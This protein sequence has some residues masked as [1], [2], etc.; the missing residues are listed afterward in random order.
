MKVRVYKML[1]QLKKLQERLE[2]NP[3][4]AV[5]NEKYNTL[6]KSILRYWGMK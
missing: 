6:F 1:H 5:A 4:D 2:S 3:L